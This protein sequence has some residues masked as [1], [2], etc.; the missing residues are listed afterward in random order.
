MPIT[1]KPKTRKPA[2]AD[3]DAFISGAPD[4][5][6][7]AASGGYLVGRRRQ[8]SMTI[9]PD[10]LARVDETARRTGQT[11]A[12]V[13]NLAIYHALEGDLFRR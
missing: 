12:A 6:P 1:P 10:L 11:R 8:I 3:V 9:T 2:E 7:A 4:S 13:I 5:S